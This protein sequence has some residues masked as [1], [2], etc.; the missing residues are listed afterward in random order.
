MERGL[1]NGAIPSIYRLDLK[2]G[3]DVVVLPLA[4]QEV[5]V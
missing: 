3:A 4:V 5:P 2:Q 1:Q